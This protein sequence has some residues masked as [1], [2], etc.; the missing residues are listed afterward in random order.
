MSFKRDKAIAN[1]T[2]AQ[3]GVDVS[4]RTDYRCAA[5]GCPNAASMSDGP[6]R[7]GGSCFYHWRESD[8][9]KWDSITTEIRANFDRMRN[10]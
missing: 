7:G 6:G 10:F 3:Q 9:A 8:R 2:I 5:H 1:E 4:V